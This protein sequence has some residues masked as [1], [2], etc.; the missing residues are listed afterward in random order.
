[1]TDPVSLLFSV[2]EKYPDRPAV[3]DGGVQTSYRDFARRVRAMAGAIVE[4]V[5][6]DRER[7]ILI[8]LPRGSD[9]YAAMFAC[10]YAGGYYSPANLDHPLAAQRSQIDRFEPTLCIGP[11]VELEKLGVTSPI[12]DPSIP[13]STQL[14]ASEPAHDLAYVMFTSGSTGE[15]KGVMVGRAALAHYVGWAKT[16]IV[17]GPGD[18]WSQHPNLGF[19]LSVLDIYGALCSG[20]TLVPINGRGERLVPVA[21]IR[22]HRLTIWNSVPSV[23]DLMRRGERMTSKALESLRLMTFCGEPLLPQHL[24]AIFSA[25]PDLRV[26]NTYGPTEATVSMT[27]LALTSRNY[28]ERCQ[29]NVAIGAPISGMHIVLENGPTG[30]EGEIVIVGPQVARGY[31]RDP[32]QTEARFETREIAGERLPAYRT[33]DWVERRGSDLFFTSRIDRQVKINGYRLE[34]SAVEAAL[35][36]A[37]A[38]AACVVFHRGQLVGFVEAESKINDATVFRRD[39][40][41]RVPAYAIP[42]ELHVLNKLPRNANDKIDVSALVSLLEVAESP[43]DVISPE[44]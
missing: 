4:A 13:M 38:I 9:A 20:A 22:N 34:L 41:E 3:E 6:I 5:P 30:D 10:L 44:G 14:E 8:R 43:T 1:M 21:A 31:W 29:D 12:L 33:G 32:V 40:V 11:R 18:R 16:A 27:E 37:G 35:R 19:D 2:A 23:V 26:L 39:L 15:P 42:A 36:D 24:D 25:R 7:R 17:A 28:R